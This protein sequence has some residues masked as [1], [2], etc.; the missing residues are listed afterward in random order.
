MAPGRQ[1]AQGVSGRLSLAG[2]T[3]GREALIK[4]VVYWTALHAWFVHPC[5]LQTGT[6]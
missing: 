3:L 6:V 5:P 4:G 1:S 2:R